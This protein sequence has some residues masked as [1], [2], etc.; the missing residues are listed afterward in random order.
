MVRCQLEERRR[1]GSGGMLTDCLGALAAEEVIAVSPAASGAWLLGAM[2]ERLSVVWR[3]ERRRTRG[4]ISVLG[5]S[6]LTLAC[7]V[8]GTGARCLSFPAGDCALPPRQGEVSF[9]AV[10]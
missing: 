10:F 2:H 8:S 4:R 9:C 5:V 3:C 1:F 7:A 6:A